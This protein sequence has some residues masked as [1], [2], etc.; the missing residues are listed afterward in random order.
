M[1]KRCDGITIL[2]KD[3]NN[4]L[5]N[6]QDHNIFVISNEKM[7]I[8]FVWR[9]NFTI[10]ALNISDSGQLGDISVNLVHVLRAW[11]TRHV[12]KPIAP[13]AYHVNR[14]GESMKPRSADN[15]LGYVIR[16]TNLED[17]EASVV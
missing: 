11:L 15:L 14:R 4:C 3:T 9:F 2:Y 17:D 13:P 10:S 1:P 5:Q 8:Y 6:L 12:A 7:K 16:Q